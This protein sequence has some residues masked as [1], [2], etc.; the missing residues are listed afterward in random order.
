MSRARRGTRPPRHRSGH[1]RAGPGREPRSAKYRTSLSGRLTGRAVEELERALEV[2]ERI[3][4]SCGSHARLRLGLGELH[5]L[6]VA[7]HDLALLLGRQSSAQP[8]LLRDERMRQIEAAGSSGSA[9]AARGMNCSALSGRKRPS[10]AAASV[11]NHAHSKASDAARLADA[12]VVLGR[13]A[14][15]LRRARRR[16]RCE[17]RRAPSP[18]RRPP[19]VSDRSATGC[20]T[21]GT[22]G[23]CSPGR[24]SARAPVHRVV[25]CRDRRCQP[26]TAPRPARRAVG[27]ASAGLGVAGVAGSGALVGAVAGG[28]GVSAPRHPDPSPAAD[29]DVR[30]RRLHRDFVRAAVA[31]LVP[32]LDAEQVVPRTARCGSARAPIR[33][34]RPGR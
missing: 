9:A 18:A 27:G 1:A 15:R 13:A 14:G 19:S 6:F 5:R 21:S 22:R 30:L 28:D 3:Q 25:A 34:C 16:C 8:L 11:R 17:G 2:P 7:A 33:R 32:G 12:R 20:P 31:V 29:R 4:E 10:S 23:S 24:S 26:A